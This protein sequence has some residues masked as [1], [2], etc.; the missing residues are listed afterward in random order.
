L[1]GHKRIFGCLEGRAVHL[2][3]LVDIKDDGATYS[4][5]VPRDLCE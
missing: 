1:H 2:R 4:R 3:Y 5:R